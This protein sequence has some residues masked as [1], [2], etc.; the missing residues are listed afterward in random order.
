[1]HFV[2]FCALCSFLSAKERIM[3]FDLFK[4]LIARKGAFQWALRG[5]TSF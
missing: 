5:E 1:M 2:K 4:N 3:H